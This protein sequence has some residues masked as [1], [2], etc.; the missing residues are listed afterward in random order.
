MNDDLARKS[1]PAPTDAD[2]APDAGTS[3]DAAPVRAGTSI[4]RQAGR[5]ALLSLAA[6]PAPILVAAVEWWLKTR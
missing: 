2:P 5:T 3:M 1:A 6:T 4:L